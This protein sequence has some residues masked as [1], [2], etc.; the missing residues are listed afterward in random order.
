MI[1]L[2]FVPLIFLFALG[3]T[4]VG[5]AALFPPKPSI[6]DSH[7]RVRQQVKLRAIERQR[8]QYNSVGHLKDPPAVRPVNPTPVIDS[9]HWA[10]VMRTAKK[11]A[12]ANNADDEKEA[13]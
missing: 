11:E 2:L 12:A 3:V 10:L 5:Y 6:Y 8:T 1:F 9:A 7:G 13:P 4:L